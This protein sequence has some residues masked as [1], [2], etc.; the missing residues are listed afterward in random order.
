MFVTV[1][2]THL[3][4]HYNIEVKH[5]KGNTMA[6]RTVKKCLDLTGCKYELIEVVDEHL[7]VKIITKLSNCPQCDGLA[8]HHLYV[9]KRNMQVQ[10]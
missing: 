8:T 2:I 10:E 4:Y 3:V 7:T 6:Q 9:D 5:I 1:L